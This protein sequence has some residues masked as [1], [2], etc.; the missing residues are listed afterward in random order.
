MAHEP[1]EGGGDVKH[2]PAWAQP[3]A[4]GLHQL[5]TGHKI[6]V[7]VVQGQAGEPVLS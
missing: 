7:A 2:A 3:A 5:H 4:W 1:V 6:M